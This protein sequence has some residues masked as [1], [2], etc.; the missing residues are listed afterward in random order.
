MK[1]D[2]RAAK[3]AAWV[4]ELGELAIKDREAYRMV[5]AKAWELIAN[6]ADSNKSNFI[7]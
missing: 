5:R 2:E 4:R 1:K 3:R 7:N 6:S